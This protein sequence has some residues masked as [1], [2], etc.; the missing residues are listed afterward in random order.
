MV[1]EIFLFVAQIFEELGVELPTGVS[2]SLPSNKWVVADIISGEGMGA[3]TIV[4]S[5]TTVLSSFEVRVEVRALLLRELG[6]TFG[7]G[8]SCMVAIEAV[9]MHA[10]RVKKRGF[11]KIFF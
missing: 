4:V 1:G 6:A 2:V 11:L 3:D 8:S 5:S 9:S 10:R 7:G